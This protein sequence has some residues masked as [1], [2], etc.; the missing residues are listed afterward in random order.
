MIGDFI[1]EE[2]AT[3]QSSPLTHQ[4]RLLAIAEQEIECTNDSIPGKVRNGNEYLDCPVCEGTGKVA[5]FP[6]LRQEC[7]CGKRWPVCD[8][9]Y[10]LNRRSSRPD[11]KGTHSPFCSGL[12]R[13]RGW[14]PVDNADATV[15]AMACL[16]LDGA[17]RA[18]HG[19]VSYWYVE[20]DRDHQ[21]AGMG[22]GLSLNEAL[23]AALYKALV[24]ERK[25]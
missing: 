20:L 5:R 13:G 21:L 11:D 3:T 18:P 22:Q 24:L 23:V 12:C 8:V 4:D 19:I 17:W 9:C 7:P 6:M 10:R 1:G 16:G 25:E 2:G 15:R 14:L